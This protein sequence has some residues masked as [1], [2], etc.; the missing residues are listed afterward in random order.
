MVGFTLKIID[1]LDYFLKSQNP[2]LFKSVE[3][4]G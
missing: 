1:F 2:R 4:N 3:N